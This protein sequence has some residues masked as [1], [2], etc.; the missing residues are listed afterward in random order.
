MLNLFVSF[1]RA[2][3]HPFIFTSLKLLMFSFKV[4]FIAELFKAKIHT[5]VPPRLGYSLIISLI[6]NS[7]GDV[8]GIVY[9]GL[10]Y[11]SDSFFI[12]EVA[13]ICRKL[14]R[15]ISIAEGVLFA[16]F[17]NGLIQLD[18]GKKLSRTAIVFST[19]GAFL[20]F[21][22]LLSITLPIKRL[23][24]M[25]TL[26]DI[27]L[28]VYRITIFYSLTVL[29]TTLHHALRSIRSNVLPR[30]LTAQLRALLM[31]ALTPYVSI[32]CI[33]FLITLFSDIG[34]QEF[35]PIFGLSAIA[36][37]YIFYICSRRIMK[38]RFLNLYEDVQVKYDSEFIK[39]FNDALAGL[40]KA[41]AL[42][43]VE[44]VTK[45]FV[46]EAFEI[47][48]EKTLVFVRPLR[49]NQALPELDL[50]QEGLQLTIENHLANAPQNQAL[51]ALLEQSKILVLD[52]LEFTYFYQPDEL[53]KRAIT[54]LKSA[55]AEVFLPIYD[56]HFL[57]GYVIVCQGARAHKLY[58]AVDKEEMI[59][60]AIYLERVI[61]LLQHA[62][63]E[64]V[65]KKQ[66]A[67]NDELKEKDHELN[68]YKDALLSFNQYRRD[69]KI[70]IIQYKNR[71]FKYVNTEARHVIPID[72]DNEAG[73]YV[74]QTLK[75]LGDQIKE[76]GT[77]HV[78]LSYD[79]EGHPLFIRGM[80]NSHDSSIIFI[81]MHAEIGDILNYTLPTLSAS[82]DWDYALFLQTTKA[83]KRIN[84]LIPGATP[85]ITQFKMSLLRAAISEKPL[86]L[87]IPEEDVAFVS[88]IIH[89]TSS[90][91]Y[92]E[93][94]EVLQPEKNNEVGLKLLGSNPLLERAPKERPFL[95]KLNALGTLL[96]KNIDL[97]HIETQ[98]A[99]VEYLR[100]GFFHP[101]RSDRRIETD[102]RLILSSTKDIKSLV[103]EGEFSL[104]LAE[105]LSQWTITL[106][107]ISQLP[108]AEQESLIE[109]YRKQILHKEAAQT[110]LEISPKEKASIIERKP[111]SLD[112]LRRCVHLLIASKAAKKKIPEFAL[113]NAPVAADPELQK[114][115]VLGKNALKDARIVTMLWHK[116]KSQAKIAQFLGVNRSSVHKRCKEYNLS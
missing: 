65:L 41:T 17:I 45:N 42:Y 27:D 21:C 64:L 94:L 25:D 109:S 77:A 54:F 28:T 97:L 72:L 99:L 30:I 32:G 22:Q 2:V 92:F 103:H 62:N 85:T 96:I 59:A 61:N 29:A 43:Q 60:M 112:E 20:L 3:T 104:E 106:P 6:I 33:I 70:G 49:S 76:D 38:L 75:G 34:K 113:D 16:L 102:V 58:S 39:Y 82:A 18:R 57:I 24:V 73:H 55:E 81:V 14:T 90:R 87:H 12:N 53:V 26:L 69:R 115:A 56:K 91:T 78:T 67:L 35:Y 23:Q 107:L 48:F 71:H 116:F 7:L 101:L 74:T 110:L 31:Y 1:F 40:A 13:S 95:E 114:A 46:R 9:I 83:G 52:D 89:Y 50:Y 68:L 63:P 111:S 5:K 84:E 108:I 79:H 66:K 80:P 8:L 36:V 19:L 4:Y 44:T 15:P 100:Y 11:L 98:I 51:R 88:D 86:F 93:V 37:N 105:E 10:K 47:P